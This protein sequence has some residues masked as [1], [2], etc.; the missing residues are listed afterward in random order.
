MKVVLF[1]GGQ[2]MRLREYS[3]QIPKPMV[4]IGYRPILWHVMKYYAEHGHKDFIL[5]LGYKA[6]TIKKYFLNYDEALSNDFVLRN[7]GQD[8][9][10]L[11]SDIHDWNITFVDTGMNTN[12][13]ERLKAVEKHL[14]GE[15]YFLA[16]YSDGLTD[17]PLSDMLQNLKD[18][19]RTASFLCVRPNQTFHVVQLRD[20]GVV[21]GI[22]D[23]RMADVRINGGYFA[24]KTEIFE[25]MHPGEEL[26]T[27]PF[28]RLIR[29][30]ELIAYP[31]DG[32]WASMDTFKDKQRLDELHARGEAPWEI[33]KSRGRG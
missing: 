15:E 9:Q 11:A 30:E 19:D 29:E 24:F 7:G 31:H 8:V 20:K 10:L 6:D 12:I 14:A 23:I 32:F 21:T 18:L 4:P 26:V 27:E 1:C 5:C 22:E 28:Q 13:G 2:G 25:Y 17:C 3:E 16:N 33:W